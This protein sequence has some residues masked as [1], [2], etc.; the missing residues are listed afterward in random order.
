MVLGEQ[1]LLGPLPA[2]IDCGKLLVQEVLLEQLLPD[3]QRQ[4]HLK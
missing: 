4:G 3:P 2:G 1:K